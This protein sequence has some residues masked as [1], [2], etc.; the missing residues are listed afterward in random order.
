M[1]QNVANA[2]TTFISKLGVDTLFGVS[3]ANIEAVFHET[4]SHSKLE[5]ILAKHEA[6]AVHMAMGSVKA[7]APIGVVAVTSGGGAFNTISPLAEAYSESCPVLVLMGQVAQQK[8]G[9]GSFQE[10]DGNQGTPNLKKAV[11]AVSRWCEVLEDINDLPN[12]LHDAV[13][14]L[15]GPKPG[16][17]VLMI[18]QNFYAMD[19]PNGMVQ[20]LHEQAPK[21]AHIPVYPQLKDRNVVA[22]LGR[23]ILKQNV[24]A[25]VTSLMHTLQ[26]PVTV[27][28]DAKGVFDNQD[29]L[30]VGVAGA[31]GNPSA[32]E[33]LTEAEVVLVIGARLTQ[34]ELFGW[35][36]NF[37][38]KEVYVVCENEC[39]IAH[40]VTSW[41][42]D[43]A[44]VLE[45]LNETY[46]QA[47]KI[48]PIEVTY[49]LKDAPTHIYQDYA[50]AVQPFISN[51]DHVVVDA[52]NCGGS[53]VHFLQLPFGAHF[54]IALG[55][56]GMGYSF[57][58]AIGAAKTSGNR[59]WVFAGDG[60]FYMHGMEIHTAIEYDIP[61]TFIIFDNHGHAMCETREQTFFCAPSHYNTFKTELN[62]DGLRALFPQLQAYDVST[63]EELAALLK[64]ETPQSG[65]MAIV[66]KVP[67]D[68]EVPFWPFLHV[69]GCLK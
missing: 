40:R 46:S 54:D 36:E 55:M 39:F 56:G 43:I 58:A 32:Q 8:R 44:T 24:V 14:T 61:V 22:L 30:Y 59:S 60:A 31:M 13:A 27:T 12:L 6:A 15:R 69:E 17:A 68:T 28:T 23:D 53:M 25:G 7:G 51:C 1:S 42:N 33:L 63:A 26:I 50:H 62:G 10:S 2:F 18:P 19:A 45:L 16:P 47:E 11:E 48:D 64:E 38:D 66:V 21:I 65:P 67:V 52:G 35:S 29:N 37:D 34:L 4:H 49:L 20:E 41:G 5:G 3:G 9:V 57:G